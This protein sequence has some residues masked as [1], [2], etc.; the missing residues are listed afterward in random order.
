MSID[1]YLDNLSRDIIKLDIS[2]KGLSKLPDISRFT[3]LQILYC[4]NNKI[5]VLPKLNCTIKKIYCSR[6]QIYKIDELPKELFMLDCDNNKLLVLPELPVNLSILH[7]NDNQLISLPSLPD[8]IVEL[9]CYNNRLEKLP[10]LP[11]KLKTC[12]C[13][14]NKLSGFPPFPPD[15][16]RFECLHNQLTS[17]P[18]LNDKMYVNFYGNPVLNEIF[19]AEYNVD[20]VDLPNY[21]PYGM[22]QYTREELQKIVKTIYNFRYIYYSIKCKRRFLQWKP[23]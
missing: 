3:N 10:R 19:S 8:T 16:Y 9:S 18:L 23:R 11:K 7:C 17:L 15:L 6:N 1:S 22:H 21:D 4:N 13:S 20:D 14:N 5:S 2:G 12:I